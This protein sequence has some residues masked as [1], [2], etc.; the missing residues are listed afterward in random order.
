MRIFWADIMLRLAV[1]LASVR[2]DLRQ[3]EYS[4]PMGLDASTLRAYIARQPVHVPYGALKRRA[5]EW[6]PETEQ[7]HG[8]RRL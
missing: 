1:G 5:P 8:C 6:G 3:M 4:W 7:L 2:D